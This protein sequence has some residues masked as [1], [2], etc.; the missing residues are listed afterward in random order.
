MDQF[1][2]P[3]DPGLA[4]NAIAGLVQ[5]YAETIGELRGRCMRLE[6]QVETLAKAAHDATGANDKL[7]RVAANAASVSNAFA[8][9]LTEH[10]PGALVDP[11][12]GL[13]EALSALSVVGGPK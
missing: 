7:R 12:H 3:S 9:V 11:M 2:I 4:H 8:H 6:S 5:F 13:N 10:R 1:T